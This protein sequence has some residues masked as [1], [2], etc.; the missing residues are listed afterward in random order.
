[1]P[2]AGGIPEPRRAVHAAGDHGA[3]IGAEGRVPDGTRVRQ[4]RLEPGVVRSPGGQV[5]PRGMLPGGIAGGDR[6]PP[7]L[8]HPEEAGADLALL[9][10][11]PAAVEVA[12]RQETIRFTERFPEALSLLAEVGCQAGDFASR[13][14]LLGGVDDRNRRHR[15]Q[16]RRHGPRETGHHRVAA[17]PPGEGLEPAHRAGQYGLAPEPAAPGR[18]PGPL[19]SRNAAAGPSPGTSGRPSPGRGGP[20]D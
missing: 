6:R 4:D 3:A 18:W 8:D 11:G 2:A 17:T 12:D 13:P 16:R 15:H 1:M 20:G 9:E 7:A 10:G 5:G 19:P 14:G